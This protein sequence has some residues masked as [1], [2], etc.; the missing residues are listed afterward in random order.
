MDELAVGPAQGEHRA[1]EKRGASQGR[2]R[3]FATTLPWPAREGCVD[4]LHDD[5]VLPEPVDRVRDEA[6]EGSAS[7]EGNEVEDVGYYAEP[8]AG[9]D[10][11]R[12][13]RWRSWRGEAK[14]PTEEVSAGVKLLNVRPPA[15]AVDV[16]FVNGL[17]LG[18]QVARTGR[19]PRLRGRPQAERAGVPFASCDEDRG[20]EPARR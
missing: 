9:S 8:A 18:D 13:G 16:G 15:I 17:L 14:T 11:G 12:P 1:R 5:A 4:D 6:T 2:R 19:R 20:S 3:S 10:H 7:P